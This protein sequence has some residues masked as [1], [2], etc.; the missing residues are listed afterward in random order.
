MAR[1]QD[2]F[3]QNLLRNITDYYTATY[4]T[5]TDLY[6]LLQ[7]YS[8]EFSSGSIALDIVRDNTFIVTCEESQLFPNFGTFFNIEKVPDQSPFEDR[9][10]DYTSGSTRTATPTVLEYREETIIPGTW[11]K[12][13]I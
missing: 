5:D 10:L 8:T 6:S 4:S 3:L 11:T 13:P 12:Q 2:Q 7:M 1:S 9:Y